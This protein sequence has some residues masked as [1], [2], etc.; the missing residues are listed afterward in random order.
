MT[1]RWKPYSSTIVSKFL[2]A[3]TG[4][5]LIV[6]LVIHLAGNLLLFLGPE[7]FNG[8]AHAL[9]SNPLIIVI[10]IG[11]A[12][13][14]VLHIYETVVTWIGNR[15]ARPEGYY[16]K[17]WARGAS[18]KSVASTTMIF[19][20]IVTAVFVV[21]HVRTFRF[22]VHYEVPGSGER[23]LYRLVMEVFSD[24]VSVVFYELVLVLVGLHLWHGF[25]SS[26]ES[27]GGNHPRFTPAAIAAGRVVAIVLGG[28]FIVIPLW[29][30]FFGGTP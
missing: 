22:G 26:L 29:V 16:Q 9:V 5:A 12:A 8:Y 28:G 19:T 6:Y 10:E 17:A 30:Y 15:G 4:L 20:G 25:S 21:L 13:I 14:F 24:P 27:L 7:T 18:R 1:T 23:D 2:I 3:V 11:L